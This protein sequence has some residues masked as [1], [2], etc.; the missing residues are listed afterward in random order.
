M[1]TRRNKRVGWH[2]TPFSKGQAKPTRH[3]RHPSPRKSAKIVANCGSWAR[4]PRVLPVE[5]STRGISK[6]PRKAR[7][8]PFR[9][10]VPSHPLDQLLERRLAPQRPHHRIHGEDYDPGVPLVGRNGQE[11]ERAVRLA[12]REVDGRRLV[13]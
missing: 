8:V 13:G 6:A 7:P 5:R 12:Q 9:P 10:S 3:L 4:P 2:Y 1:R 11:L